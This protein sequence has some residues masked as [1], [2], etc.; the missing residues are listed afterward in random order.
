MALGDRAQT[1]G[2]IQQRPFGAQHLRA[3]PR[4][5]GLAVHVAQLTVEQ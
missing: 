1:L 2:L 4:G 5:F 3:F